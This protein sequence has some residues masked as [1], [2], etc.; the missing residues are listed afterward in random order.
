MSSG[1]SHTLVPALI[2]YL[3]PATP[4]TLFSYKF[5]TIAT[6]PAVHSTINNAACPFP[7]IKLMA[8][9]I[10]A[11]P[12][13]SSSTH[14]TVATSAHIN[15]FAN[16]TELPIPIAIS[17]TNIVA[18]ESWSHLAKAVTTA[19]VAETVK[20][21][22]ALARSQQVKKNGEESK[23]IDSEQ[24]RRFTHDFQ[25]AE[26]EDIGATVVEVLGHGGLQGLSGF[27]LLCRVMQVH[28]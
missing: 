4:I 26:V 19:S 3:P 18:A 14:T 24:S 10:A 13:Y 16:S 23:G 7:F 15:P 27:L 28:W 2:S 1:A 8:L 22:K 20:V 21:V 6:L 25:N 11:N 17:A 12:V 5:S 9:A